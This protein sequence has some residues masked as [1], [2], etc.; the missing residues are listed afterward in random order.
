MFLHYILHE[1]LVAQINEPHPG[2][3]WLT[4]LNDAEELELKMSLH[5]IKS[6]SKAAFKM[7]VKQ[8]AS[9]LALN[10]LQLKK[11]G[12]KKVQNC[13]YKNLQM[14]EY[15][16]SPHLSINQ[17]KFLFHLRTRMFFLRSNYQHMYDDEYCPICSSISSGERFRD[18][19]EHLLSCNMLCNATD[20]ENIGVCYSDLFGENQELQAKV[21]ILIENKFKLRKQIE[22]KNT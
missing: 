16:S 13:H 6:V 7:K 4:A 22:D 5:E 12:L 1:F 18:N 21:T 19:Q 17:T 8:A 2:D 14:Q 11:S 15:L 10:W 9:D 3:W 20:I